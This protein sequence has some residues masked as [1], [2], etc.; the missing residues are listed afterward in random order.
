M[1]ALQL[2][3]LTDGKGRYDNTDALANIMDS[4]RPRILANMTGM[5]MRKAISVSI[6]ATD[7]TA[8][9]CSRLS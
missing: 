4:T 8:L 9:A 3:L 6:E 5:A 1:T 2:L 7:H